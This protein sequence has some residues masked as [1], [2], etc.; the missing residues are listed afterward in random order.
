MEKDIM[1][2][3]LADLRAKKKIGLRQLARMAQVSPASLVA[4][5]K[6]STSPTLATLNKI[7]KAMGSNF[8]EFFSDR[9]PD[10]QVPVFSRAEMRSFN[11]VHREYTLLFPKRAGMRFEMIL[12]TISHSE[13][14]VE[15][16]VH[17][18]DL[19]GIVL[20]GQQATLEIAGIGKWNLSKGDA[21]YIP[22]GSK[23]RLINSGEQPLKQVTV[24]SPPKY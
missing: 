17:D 6:G 23:H 20:S 4:I 15:W 3:S 21:Y 10:P 9:L 12:E 22:A 5:E 8:N 16:E 1:G 7:L 13:K 24:V 19:G 18:C 11:D 2:Q 14:I